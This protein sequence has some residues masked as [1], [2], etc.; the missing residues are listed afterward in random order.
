MSTNFRQEL[1]EP[2]PGEVFWTLVVTE[3]QGEGRVRKIK[4]NMAQTRNSFR[5]KKNC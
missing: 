4:E 5:A 2:S 1:I 3:E